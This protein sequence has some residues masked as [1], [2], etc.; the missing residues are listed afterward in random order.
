MAL[1]G[2]LIDTSAYSAS[3][4]GD[5]GALSALQNASLIFLPM[6]VLGELLAG[7]ETGRRRQQNRIELREFQRSSRVQLVSATADTAERYAV[8]YA[9]LRERG[10]PIPTN[11]LWIAATAMEQGITLLTADSH[12]LN[13]PQIV[14]RYLEPE[15][16]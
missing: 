5:S 1:R 4:R 8:I 3:K 14:V 12:F 13:L 10:R 6:V 16:P 2:V 9:Y 11:D 7:F 15:R